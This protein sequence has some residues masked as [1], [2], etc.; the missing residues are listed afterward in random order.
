MNTAKARKAMSIRTTPM[1]SGRLDVRLPAHCVARVLFIIKF[2]SVIVV[3]H[4]IVV[5]FGLCF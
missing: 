5:L 4:S 1:A 3:L 2:D